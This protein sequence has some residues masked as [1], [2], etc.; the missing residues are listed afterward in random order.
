MGP[1]AEKELDLGKFPGKATLLRISTGAK[2][3]HLLGGAYQG[4]YSLIDSSS[5]RFAGTLEGIVD[6]DGRF[7]FILTAD[8]VRGINGVLEGMLDQMELDMGTIYTEPEGLRN[9]PQFERGGTPFM[10]RSVEY[11]LTHLTGSFRPQGAKEWL[12]SLDCDLRSVDD[13]PN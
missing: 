11:G 9:S 7:G 12:Q 2:R 13:F 3:G 5:T 1:I 8:P 4:T 10:I 6:A